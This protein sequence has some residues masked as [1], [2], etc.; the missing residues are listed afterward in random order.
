MKS[1]NNESDKYKF[2]SNFLVFFDAR[3][4]APGVGGLPLLVITSDTLV[5]RTY[6]GVGFF[7]SKRFAF[8]RSRFVHASGVV[9]VSEITKENAAAMMD[10]LA[11]SR[12]E[13]DPLMMCDPF[14][15]ENVH[16]AQS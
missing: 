1:S 6:A 3:A 4:S 5:V 9:E 15:L 10:I 2:P 11:K 16:R 12:L 13:V 7:S 14:R 8:H